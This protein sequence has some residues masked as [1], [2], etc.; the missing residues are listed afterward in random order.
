MTAALFPVAHENPEPESL[1]I[2][3]HEGR[4]QGSREIWNI[5]G[6][7]GGQEQEV[8]RARGRRKQGAC[9]PGAQVGRVVKDRDQVAS[10]GETG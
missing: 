9:T 4:G 10:P 2:E 3:L 7:K 6:R 8:G 1:P 5:E